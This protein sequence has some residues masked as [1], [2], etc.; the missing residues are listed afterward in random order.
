MFLGIDCSGVNASLSLLTANGTEY[1]Q[2]ENTPRQADVIFPM[3]EKL[4]SQANIK[5]DQLTAIGVITGPG[6]FTGIRVGLALAQGL[7]DGLN[8]PAYGMDAFAAQRGKTENAFT[9]LES[10]RAELYVQHG[11]DEPQMLLAD[12]IIRFT[13]NGNLNIVHNLMPDHP[14]I[15]IL[16]E[17]SRINMA[18]IAAQFAKKQFE[19]G[20][21]SEMLSPYY[22]READAKPNPA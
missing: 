12:Q 15:K 19:A 11:D 17:A 5:A 16:G 1:H 9:V 6:S 20:Q 14:L 4:F 7:A 8:I 3:L 18:L 2:S 13:E 21:K 22:V 10:K